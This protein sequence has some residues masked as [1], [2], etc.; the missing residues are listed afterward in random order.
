MRTHMNL[1]RIGLW[2]GVSALIAAQAVSA[3][4]AVL[5]E[6]LLIV[7][8]STSMQYRLF[9]DQAPVCGQT[10]VADGRSRWVAAHEIIG[11]SY[12]SYSCTQQA[13]PA[14]P[15][16]LAPPAPANG[17][18]KC[19]PGLPMTMVSGSACPS[20]GPTVA[21]IPSGKTGLGVSSSTPAG[22]DGLLDTFGPGAKFAL[23]LSDS[24]LNKGSTAAAGFSFG[25][26]MTSYWGAANLGMQDPFVAGTNSVAIA[27]PDDLASRAATY[28][29]IQNALV[30][31]VANGPTPLGRQLLDALAYL[32]PG[33]YQDAHFK[34]LA[35]D[36][37][38]GDQYAKCRS[39]LAVVISDGGSNLD[40]GSSDGR[41][42]ALLTASKLWA[43]G[44]PVYV[45]AVG[46]PADGAFG[47]PAADLQFLK[48]LAAAGGTTTAILASTPYDAVKALAPALTAASNDV[49]VFTHPIVTL[50]T[51]V[52]TDVQH[53]FEGSSN[54]NI[55]QP[56][57]SGGTIEQRIYACTAAC[58]NSATP[59]LA[60]VCEILDYG[61]ILKARATPRLI[62]TMASG[63]R[64]GLTAS[65]VT[66]TEF[67]IGTVGLQPKLEPSVLGDCV[68]NGAFD[69]AVLS[70]REAFKQRLIDILYGKTGT[71]RATTP[72]GAPA[73]STPAV[74]EPAD[75]N[76]LREPSFQTYSKTTVPTSA[77]YS[78]ANPPGS[79]GRPTVLYAATHDG[80]LH[81][82]RTDRNPT[83]TTPNKSVAGDEMWAWLPSFN[84]R[85]LA[86]LKLVTTPEAS[87]LGGAVTAGHVQLQ[88]SAAMTDV[89]AA[90]A[91]RAVV[92]VGAGEAG[93]GYMAL[94]V[95]APEDPQ[96]LWEIAPDHHCYGPGATLSGV[97]GPRCLTT[98][99]FQNLGR[100]VPKP[101]IANL[102]FGVGS[103]TPVQR[104]V[105]VVPLG[106]PS[107]QSG[108]NNY[109]VDGLGKRGV[110]VV[111]LASGQKIREFANND[112]D[113]TGLP[114]AVTSADDVGYFYGD[115]ACYNATAGQLVT[116]CFLGDS[117]GLLWRMDLSDANPAKWT[118][119][120][121][122]DAYGG[123]GTPAAN[124]LPIGSAN[125]VP[126]LA[127]PSLAST[128]AA[129]LV[130]SYGTGGIGDSASSTRI[131]MVY[132][133][134]E[135][136]L[137]L[138]NGSTRP[139]ATVNWV[140]V[141]AAF[142][143]FIGPPVVFALNTYW[144]SFAIASEG[145]C[146]TGTGRI[147][148]ARFDKP[149]NPSDT[150][151][152]AGAFANPNGSAT[153]VVSLDIGTDRPSP[154][155]VQAVPGCRGNC[156]PTDSK[157]VGSLTGAAAAQ[158]LG[159]ARPRYAVGVATPNAAVQGA[160]QA[161]KSGTQPSV[162]TVTHDVPQPRTAAVV[163]G[164]DLLVD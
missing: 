29:A 145:A 59:E 34:T 106:M 150:T 39:R 103:E 20:E 16:A 142:E 124:V 105:A 9:G 33:T 99:T 131:H 13:L 163:T 92:L 41:A 139:V 71:C 83:I 8:S 76:G 161:P 133:L 36:P 18:V 127:A 70:D 96:L 4:A 73:K 1:R 117:K 104:A 123:P 79:A 52:V 26:D 138:G 77:S 116:R 84:L 81:S 128:T 67:G 156:S 97:P 135:D 108:V 23:L 78:G 48:D 60:Q 56:L 162:G 130:V 115:P 49:Q 66:S 72:L 110:L 12:L 24:V 111:D 160:G 125:R 107:A 61:S 90:A 140:Q 143:R 43:M 119:A 14:L 45:I 137:T 37:V 88:R 91:W 153:K 120:F 65:N 10:G 126:I 122:H 89:Q 42:T 93:S 102:Y 5:P 86:S 147:W 129:R 85:K 68:T 25:P 6:V 82:F 15:E 51:G 22:Q 141:L 95:T 118:I 136:Q 148:G 151:T 2:C 155:D 75:R 35:E 38:N 21:T 17:A 50:A 57:R 113:L 31:Q 63:V 11:G 164:W 64:E 46:H 3:W 40:D 154:V 27:R 80:V 149:L 19:I 87:Y 7:D 112:L 98:T 44:V 62:Y 58:K 152:L 121:F 47:P 28:T 53:G 69:L 94:D 74:I 100:S 114:T 144:A 109:G 32:S 54:F 146:E 157:C 132:S 159:A 101:L 30:N 55:S 158:A 134:T